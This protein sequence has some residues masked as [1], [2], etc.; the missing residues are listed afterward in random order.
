MSVHSK[1]LVTSVS[2]RCDIPVYS[3]LMIGVE[4]YLRM[5][6]GVNNP[7]LKVMKLRRMKVQV[8]SLTLQYQHR[9]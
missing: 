9:R 3:K 6:I 1:V 8:M 7:I 5:W 2:G 4:G